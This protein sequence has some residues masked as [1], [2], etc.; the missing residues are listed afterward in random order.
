MIKGRKVYDPL[1]N[2]YSTGWWIVDDN[3][4]YYPVW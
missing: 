1:T 3:G 4:N 2:T